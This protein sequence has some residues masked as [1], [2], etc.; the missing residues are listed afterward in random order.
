M[1]RLGE[2]KN[3]YY[4]IQALKNNDTND[5]YLYMYLYFICAI[6]MIMFVWNDD[7]DINVIDNNDINNNDDK[8]IRI[9]CTAQEVQKYCA[10]SYC[11]FS[12]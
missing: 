2:N 10:I 6:K 5:I 3:I 11:M 12:C 9:N 1:K 7:V 8:N 4:C